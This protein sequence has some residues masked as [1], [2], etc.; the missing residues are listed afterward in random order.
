MEHETLKHF[1]YHKWANKRVFDHLKSLPEEL[2]TRK[3][4]NVFSSI[5]EVVVHMCVADA[6]WLKIL[7]GG[8]YEE[9][10]ELAMLL[11]N[12]LLEKDIEGL[13]SFF[14]ETAH[15][16]E[17]LFASLDDLNCDLTIEH[18]AFGRM[19]TAF[20]EIVNHVV[21]HGTYHRGNITSMLRQMGHAGTATDYVYYLLSRHESASSK[22]PPV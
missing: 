15:R 2:F 17:T 10:K 11:R 1:D 8:R 20:S 3:I 5:A 6:L 13:A 14:D 16:Y 21:N 12:E 4:E 22:N 18:P 9:A 7:S 19:T